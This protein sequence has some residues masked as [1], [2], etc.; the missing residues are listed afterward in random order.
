MLRD[1]RTARSRHPLVWVGLV[2]G[3][4][5]L[6]L[7]AGGCG[8][9]GEEGDTQDPDASQGP[10]PAPTTALTVA[11]LPDF[12][13]QGSDVPVELELVP[14]LNESQVE[15]TAD[16]ELPDPEASLTGFRSVS[17]TVSLSNRAFPSLDDVRALQRHTEEAVEIPSTDGFGEKS[18]LYR[19]TVL[20]DHANHHIYYGYIKQAGLTATVIGVQGTLPGASPEE[21]EAT[22]A[23]ILL[24]MQS[25]EARLLGSGS[26]AAAIAEPTPTPRVFTRFDLPGFVLQRSD[27]PAGLDLLST[28]EDSE[29]E[30]S[31][32]YELPD[33]EASLTGLRSVSST[34]H[35]GDRGFPSLDDVRALQRHTE[36]AVEIPEISGFGD[37]SILYR[38]TVLADHAEHHIYYG[39]INFGGL[40]ATVIGVQGTVPEPSLEEIEATV[41]DILVLMQSQEARLLASSS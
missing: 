19:V 18:I 15:Y 16:Y 3:A 33:P 32:G 37:E 38:V 8:G 30:Y 11:D 26:A 2:A 29:V 14:T 5:G 40:S 24:L 41:A 27:V 4:V 6:L 31:V 20:A 1:H 17:S 10:T 12:V 28:D 9:V 7:A 34:V 36:D 23:G 22:L 39:Y 21:V 13:L 25:Q 35:I